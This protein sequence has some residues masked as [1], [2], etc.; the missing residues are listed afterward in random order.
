MCLTDRMSDVEIRDNR[1]QRQYE[2]VV[3]GVVAGYAQYRLAG[4]RIT[5]VHTVVEPEYKGGGVGSQLVRGALDDVRA[6]GDLDVV[7]QCPFVRAWLRR[8]RDYWDLLVDDAEFV[9][10]R[11]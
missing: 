3:D 6:R 8:H 7:A 10:D 5:F 11:A 2:A 4:E 9:A 1:G